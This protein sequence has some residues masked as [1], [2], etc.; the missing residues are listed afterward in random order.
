ML[1]SYLLKFENIFFN[2]LL[3]EYFNIYI[4]FFQRIFNDFVRN[5]MLIDYLKISKFELT[6]QL[7]K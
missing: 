4:L 2:Y 7:I 3:N 5:F 6:Q 1:F